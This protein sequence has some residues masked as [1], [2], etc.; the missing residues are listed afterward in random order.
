MPLFPPIFGRNQGNGQ[1]GVHSQHRPTVKRVEGRTVTRPSLTVRYE[2]V[3]VSACTRPAPCTREVYGSTVCS[4]VYPGGRRCTYPGRLPTHHGRG[5]IYPGLYLSPGYPSRVIPLTG[6]I[7]PGLILPVP[8]GYSRVN[9]PS[10]RRLF[11]GVVYS[12]FILPG[13]VYSGFI[14][15]GGFPPGL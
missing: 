6:F 13:V 7:P 4:M 9:T 15:P 11:P 14:L 8:E 3:Q 10:S 12:R 1:T 5:G 2:S